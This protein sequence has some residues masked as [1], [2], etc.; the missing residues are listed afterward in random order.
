MKT[1]RRDFV[2]TTGA[3]ALGSILAP[4]ILKGSSFGLAAAPAIGI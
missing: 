4:S 1:N 3:V 2:K